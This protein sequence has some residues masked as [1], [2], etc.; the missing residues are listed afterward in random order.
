VKAWGP[1]HG[2]RRSA[3]IRKTG[4]TQTHDKNN[5]TTHDKNNRHGLF[6]ARRLVVGGNS[7]LYIGIYLWHRRLTTLPGQS[8]IRYPLPPPGFGESVIHLA[9]ATGKPLGFLWIRVEGFMKWAKNNLDSGFYF[10]AARI[11]HVGSRTAPYTTG[12]ICGIDG[13]VTGSNSRV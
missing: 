6:T 2:S 8:W 9:S 11:A 1:N 7:T 10:F 12:Y 4:H 13:S 3:V 5:T